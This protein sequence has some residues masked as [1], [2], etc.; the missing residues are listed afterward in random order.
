MFVVDDPMLALIVRF[1]AS[2]P[3]VDVTENGFLQRQVETMSQYLTRYPE[4][5]R[6]QRALEWVARYAEEYRSHWQRRMVSQ[7][8]EQ[9]RCL[10]CPMNTLEQESHCPVHYQWQALLQRYTRD[11]L[12]S[13]DYVVEALQMLRE[14]KQE[15]KVRKQR[16][17]E[18]RRQLKAFHEA[19]NRSL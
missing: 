17:A 2:G 1:V 14:H 15:L 7:Q 18:D 11:E 5:E 19:T 10:D 12:S 9:S 3:G 16:E 8:A 4:Q 13:V 6:E